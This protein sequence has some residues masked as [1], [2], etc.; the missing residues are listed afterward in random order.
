MSAAEQRQ[1]LSPVIALLMA[2]FLMHVWLEVFGFAPT[3]VIVLGLGVLI[4]TQGLE[5]P[6]V[7]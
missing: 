7:H 5:V 3:L 1:E 4:V 6:W 2:F